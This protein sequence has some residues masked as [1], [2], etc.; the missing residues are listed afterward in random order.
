M[1]YQEIIYEEVKRVMEKEE[2]EPLY[3]R[4]E[5]VSLRDIINNHGLIYNDVILAPK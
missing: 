2:K 3:I 1:T 5:I 4:V